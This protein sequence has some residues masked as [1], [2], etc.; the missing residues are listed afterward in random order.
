MPKNGRTSSTTHRHRWAALVLAV[1]CTISGATSGAASAAEIE[2]RL[3]GRVIAIEDAGGHE[4]TFLLAQRGLQ[5][6]TAVSITLTF[7]DSAAPV[8]EDGGTAY[9]RGVVAMALS[10]GLYQV[11][12]AR[13]TGG[14]V[15]SRVLCINDANEGQGP[16]DTYSVRAPTAM[17]S[18]D[19]IRGGADKAPPTMTLTAT[20]PDGA[21]MI[22]E[23]LIQDVLRF[24]T[25]GVRLVVMGDG[26]TISIAVGEDTSAA[27]TLLCRRGQ[28]AAASKFSGS[29][30]SCRARRASKPAVKDLGGVK[31]EKCLAKA[32]SK[33][34]KAFRK[35][36]TKAERK[37][38]GCV[39]GADA[40]ESTAQVLVDAMAGLT[41][42]LLDESDRLDKVDRVLRGKLLKA[43]AAQA[44]KDLKAYLKHAKKPNQGKLDTQLV[45]NRV[46]TVQAAGKALDKAVAG[47]IDIGALSA[48]SLADS[49]RALVQAFVASIGGA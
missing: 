27:D 9:A 16:V 31:E 8:S 44:S 15:P 38:R 48:T 24:P 26:G 14:V 10:A 23:S 37:G 1:A 13:L 49:V 28:L 4:S 18:G 45:A 41:S 19:I 34:E 43:A 33:F 20:D 32:R 17:D 11:S 47:G 12:Y 35:A 21:A 42:A 36:A 6:G 5:V 25:S 30:F 40:A 7:E 39:L 46:K 2:T 29:Y 3:P 22:D